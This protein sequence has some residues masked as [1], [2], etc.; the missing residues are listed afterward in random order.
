MFDESEVAKQRLKIIKFY[1]QYGEKAAKEAFGV[2]SITLFTDG[3]KRY[4]FS[5]IDSKLYPH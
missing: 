4:I 2:D 1:Q 3:L 5:A